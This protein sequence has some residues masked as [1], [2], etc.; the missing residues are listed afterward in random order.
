[1]SSVPSKSGATNPA[2]A[3]EDGY[4]VS[5]GYAWWVFTLTFLLM[6]VDFIDRQVIV[7]MFPYL[8]AEWSLSD[9][10]LGALVSVVSVTVA[11]GAFPIALIA[12]RW[13]RVKCIFW[14]AAI[15]SAA[16]LACGAARNF[17]QLFAARAAVGVGEAGYGPAGAAMLATAFPKRWRN[18]VLAAFLAG[19][20][21]GAVLGVVL[22]GAIAARWGWQAAFGAVGLPGIALALLYLV[23][24]RDYKTV[25]LPGSSNRMSMTKF[26]GAAL[27]HPRTA[28]WV[29]IGGA[30]QLFVVSTMS[31]W[32][33][34]FFNRFY[35]LAPEKAGLK[36]AVVILMATLGAVVWGF[37]V[38]RAGRTKPR[39]KLHV[40]AVVS[41]FTP[42]VLGVAF[43]WLPSGDSQFLL[44]LAGGF[45]MTST[46]G[47]MA[48]IAVDVVHP[49]LRASAAAMVAV[50]T[51]LFG[52][53]AGPFV[54]GMLSDSFGLQTALAIVPAFCLIAAYAFARAAT[55]YEA[56][57]KKVAGIRVTSDE[58]NLRALTV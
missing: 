29:C 26:I 8:K 42:V 7:S 52:I 19:G 11:L 34:S 20:P 38:D 48:A 23:T 41:L 51:N 35:G 25:A 39:R 24:V 40:L 1:M 17:G 9:K 32:L 3:A 56:D 49:G 47:P 18:T 31:A 2:A 46:L 54:A 57:L 13:S 6:L 50:V 45:L 21:L 5:R 43:G 44:I 53:A 30:M 27:F 10:Q 16:T 22:G 4:L 37:V 15:W 36:A 14:M 33:P 58:G 55:T 28:L 12:D